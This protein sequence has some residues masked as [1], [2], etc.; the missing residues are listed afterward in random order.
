MQPIRSSAASRRP[1]IRAYVPGCE[2]KRL[3]NASIAVCIGS[4]AIFTLVISCVD[5]KRSIM[6]AKPCDLI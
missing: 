5:F 6:I 1:R 2:S 4:L 3:P